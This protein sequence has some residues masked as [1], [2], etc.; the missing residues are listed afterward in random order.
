V[1]PRTRDIVFSDELKVSLVQFG[2]YMHFATARHP[3]P[4]Q[5]AW[6]LRDIGAKSSTTASWGMSITLWRNCRHHHSTWM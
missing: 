4:E 1:D 5:F 3:D 6:Q 2:Q